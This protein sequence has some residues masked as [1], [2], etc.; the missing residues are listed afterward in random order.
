MKIF[1]CVLLLQVGLLAHQN[2]RCDL[3]AT[4]YVCGGNNG[5]GTLN[6]KKKL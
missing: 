5:R 1:L 4:R 3:V 2:F 6:F